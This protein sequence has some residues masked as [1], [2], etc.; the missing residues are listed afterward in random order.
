MVVKRVRRTYMLDKSSLVLL[1]DIKEK[2]SKL[3]DV[4]L[5]L[6]SESD[7]VNYSIRKFNEYLKEK[8]L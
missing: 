6:K 3:I 2:K 7:I 1:K 8:G 4:G 5:Y